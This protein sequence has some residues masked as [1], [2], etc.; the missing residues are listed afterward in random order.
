MDINLA[1]YIDHTY[2]KPEGTEDDIR[3]VCDE[4]RKWG[5]ATVVIHPIWVRLAKAALAGSGVGVCSVAGFP[6]GTNVS[7]AKGL[8]ARLAMEDGASELDMVMN[9]GA[10][11]ERHLTVVRQDIEYVVKH[12]RLVDEKAIVKVIIETALLTDEEKVIASKV[13]EEAGAD[14]VKTSTGFNGLTGAKV[15]DIRLIKS[16]ISP[17]IKIK[18]AGGIRTRE[19]ALAMIEAG[20]SR[21]GT[22]SAVQIMTGA[23]P[24]A[25]GAQAG[26]VD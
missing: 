25:A 13:V 11:R 7:S 3:R 19:Q 12:A 18:A 5:F 6:F 14:Y 24:Q 9:I 2:L 23:A 4:A 20:A 21:I 1:S 26:N 16:A 15:D 8:E 10:L 17:K 22:S